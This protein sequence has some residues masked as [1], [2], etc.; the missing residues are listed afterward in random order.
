MNKTIKNIIDTN[1]A[2]RGKGIK[3]SHLNL[4]F[5]KRIVKDLKQLQ[6]ELVRVDMVKILQWRALQDQIKHIKTYLMYLISECDEYDP[7]LVNLIEPIIFQNTNKEMEVERLTIQLNSLEE[8]YNK[9]KKIHIQHENLLIKRVRLV[10]AIHTFELLK[11]LKAQDDNT[12]SKEIEQVKIK[13]LKLCIVLYRTKTFLEDN[14]VRYNLN[15]MVQDS[16]FSDRSK[17]LNKPI[18]KN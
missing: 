12:C 11:N 13:N 3:H 16:F 1:M 7:L 6:R 18:Y 15:N 5:Y 8:E 10:E 17:L 2:I 9:V 14:M 4:L